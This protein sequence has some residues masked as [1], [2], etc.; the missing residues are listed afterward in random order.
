[1]ATE[2]EAEV[3]STQKRSNT[4]ASARERRGISHPRATASVCIA[5]LLLLA[6]MVAGMSNPV[7]KSARCTSSAQFASLLSAPCRLPVNGFIVD[8]SKERSIAARDAG[9]KSGMNPW[10]RG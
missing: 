10:A 9:R 1:M 4:M 3:G 7:G 6:L 2:A 8:E 5:L